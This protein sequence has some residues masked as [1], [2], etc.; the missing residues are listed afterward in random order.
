MEAWRTW[1]NQFLS[2]WKNIRSFHRRFCFC[3]N[4]RNFIFLISFIKTSDE[5]TSDS[6]GTRKA[7]LWSLGTA[8]ISGIEPRSDTE[9]QNDFEAHQG[10]SV[11]GLRKQSDAA[12]LQI[13]LKPPIDPSTKISFW[14]ADTSCPAP[15]KRLEASFPAGESSRKLN[16]SFAQSFPSWVAV[17]ALPKSFSLQPPPPKKTCFS[18][19]PINSRMH[20]YPLEFWG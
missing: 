7:T 16:G 15:R 1:M 19:M 8:R 14:G 11:V 5:A 12:I 10:G 6:G 3:P 9:A 17:P 18:P 2:L 13:F 20:S 4:G